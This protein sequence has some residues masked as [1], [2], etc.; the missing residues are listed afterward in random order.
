MF[1]VG[2]V[3]ELGLREDSMKLCFKGGLLSIHL[4]SYNVLHRLKM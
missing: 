4:K 2:H 1:H 3:L